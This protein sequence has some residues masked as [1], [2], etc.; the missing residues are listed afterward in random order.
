MVI[1]EADL[2][3]HHPVRINLRIALRVQYDS[4]IGSEVCKGD[5]RALGTHVNEIQDCV[6][7]KIILTHVSDA[8]TWGDGEKYS[9]KKPPIN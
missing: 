7:V 3:K 2:V 6:I 8:I 4:L 9:E 5:L 1:S